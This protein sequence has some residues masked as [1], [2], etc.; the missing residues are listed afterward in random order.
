MLAEGIKYVRKASPLHLSPTP[1][2]ES[3]VTRQKAASRG[4]KAA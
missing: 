3:A 4:A 2:V 1:E